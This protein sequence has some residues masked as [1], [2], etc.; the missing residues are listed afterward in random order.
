MRGA[1]KKEIGRICELNNKCRDL[2]GSCL[3]ERKWQ[4]MQTANLSKAKRKEAQNELHLVS[5]C[6]CYLFTF[7]FVSRRQIAISLKPWNRRREEFSGRESKHR[8]K[9]NKAI[10]ANSCWV[11]TM[12]LVPLNALHELLP[13][14]TTST[15]TR[16]SCPYI[17]GR[18]GIDIQMV[19]IKSSNWE[20][21]EFTCILNNLIPMDDCLK[22]SIR[23]RGMD[24]HIKMLATISEDLS[25]ISEKRDKKRDLIP[26]SCPL[27]FA[28]LYIHTQTHTNR[29]IKNREVRDA[30]RQTNIKEF[31]APMSQNELVWPDTMLRAKKGQE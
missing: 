26:T 13:L 23:I 17:L 31:K 30:G 4:V 11:C 1:R 2:L 6:T 22:L 27:I 24:T 7:D 12:C 3:V 16:Y 15:W 29:E 19:F 18:T 25:L 8:E 20:A 14:L 9:R 5:A 28:Y 10:V 21:G